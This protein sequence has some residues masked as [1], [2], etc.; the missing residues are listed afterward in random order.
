MSNEQE[1]LYNLIDNILSLDDLNLKELH[2]IV[3][4][5]DFFDHLSTSNLDYQ[6]KLMETNGEIRSFLSL[7]CEIEKLTTYYCKVRQ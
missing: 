7:G 5:N 4:K 2:H 1:I 3:I 6:L